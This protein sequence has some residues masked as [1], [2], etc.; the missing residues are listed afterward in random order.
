M[1]RNILRISKFA[2][3]ANGNSCL[4]CCSIDA[5]FP[6]NNQGVREVTLVHVILVSGKHISGARIAVLTCEHVELDEKYVQFQMTTGIRHKENKH[7]RPCRALLSLISSL[8]LCMIVW[9]TDVHALSMTVSDGTNST[10][11]GFTLVATGSAGCLT[12]YACYGVTGWSGGGTGSQTFGG[13]T[14]WLTLST[15]GGF[16]SGPI[17]SVKDSATSAVFGINGG[18]FQGFSTTTGTL[19]ITLENTFALL[20]DGTRGFGLIESGQ[21]LQPGGDVRGDSL[22]MLG[23]VDGSNLAQISKTVTGATAVASSPYSLNLSPTVNK[24]TTLADG[25][26]LKYT[27]TYN[28]TN[29]GSA[30]SKFSDPAG[31]WGNCTISSQNPGCDTNGGSAAGLF[32]PTDLNGD[33][34]SDEYAALSNIICIENGGCTATANSIPEPSSILLLGLGMVVGGVFFAC[35]LRKYKGDALEGA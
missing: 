24:T 10:T 7:M 8:V 1:C 12:G 9:T 16:T 18:V 32:D 26:N 11:F 6:L 13:G 3:I 30:T 5:Q 29:S 31:G 33:G 20:T 2:K 15:T 19:T 35:R 28:Y 22:S 21:F 25:T 17:V 34:V 27:W 4:E 23:A 14:P